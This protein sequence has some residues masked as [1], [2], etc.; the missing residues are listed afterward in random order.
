MWR[1]HGEVLR[2]KKDD[3]KEEGDEGPL[4]FCLAR[5]FGFCLGASILTPKYFL[6]KCAQRSDGLALL[7]GIERLSWIGGL[8]TSVKVST[9]N[10]GGSLLPHLVLES[11]TIRVQGRQEIF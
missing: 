5:H 1:T 4:A 10:E 2:S 8:L 11:R 9:N 3:S 6:T 7:I